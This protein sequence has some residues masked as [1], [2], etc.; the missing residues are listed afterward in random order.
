MS[1][2]GA[3]INSRVARRDSGRMIR[4]QW[5]TPLAVVALAGW[6]AIYRSLAPLAD[7]LT[8]SLLRL[9]RDS[10]LGAAVGFFLFETPKVLWLL[11][12][13]V[14]G[15]G[16]VRSFFTPERTRRLLSGKRESAGNV[17]AALLGVVTPFCS[18]SAVPL[19]LGFVTAGVP[20]G[21][22]FSFL[23]SAPMV[24]EIAL[25]LLLG[26]FGW[27]IALLYLGTGL[28]IAFGSGWVLGRLRLEK[29]VEPWVYKT[30]AGVSG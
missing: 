26:M 11:V 10:H 5:F 16:I 25:V 24:N 19:F 2:A 21:V 12:L 17:L 29:H 8:Y 23:I 14:F 22:T 18:C 20:L 9:P 7:W 27:K 4:S 3:V 13:V 15:I 6:V 30:T 28:L 1:T